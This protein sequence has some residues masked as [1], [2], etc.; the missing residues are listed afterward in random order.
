MTTLSIIEIEHTIPMLK[1]PRTIRIYRPTELSAEEAL[2]VIY[3]HDGQNVFS[4]E[5][6][7]FGKGWEVHHALHAV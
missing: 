7:S 4:G 1:S 3:M 5:T 2:P 6:A